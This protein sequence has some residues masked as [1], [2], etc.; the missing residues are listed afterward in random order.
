MTYPFSCHKSS[1][2]TC[3]ILEINAMAPDIV[4]PTFQTSIIF[5]LGI[6]L[7]C[8]FY[9]AVIIIQ[10]LILLFCLLLCCVS[11]D[12]WSPQI[13]ELGLTLRHQ[14]YLVT[15]QT[16]FT[17]LKT[18]DG[19]CSVMKLGRSRSLRIMWNSASWE[20]VGCKVWNLSVNSTQ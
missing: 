14:P 19:W 15:S 4:V 18:D 2:I 10:T 12:L 7:A 5:C 1:N 11:L 8:C 20:P 3:C 13:Q 6:F 16:L 17:A 9:E